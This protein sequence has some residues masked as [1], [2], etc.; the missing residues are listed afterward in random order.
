MTG[1]SG[2]DRAAEIIERR[3]ADLGLQRITRHPF[4]V[5]VPITHRVRMSVGG[6]D[7][8]VYPLWPNGVRTP[9]IKGTLSGPMI[10]A[11]SGNLA[12]YNGQDVEGSVVV[13]E[14]DLGVDWFHAPMLGA[15]AV[16]FVENEDATRP[17]MEYKFSTV[18]SPPRASE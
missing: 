18:P 14:G 16:V 2:A 1:T 4:D 3:F 17:Q 5:V 9:T 13:L 6:E 10:W 12:A 11:G 7:V 15:R 8:P